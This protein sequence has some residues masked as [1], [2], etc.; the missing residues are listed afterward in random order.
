VE[1]LS[2]AL[3]ATSI[4]AG[5]DGPKSAAGKIIILDGAPAGR[6][7]VGHVDERIAASV[8]AVR[9]GAGLQEQGRQHEQHQS[10]SHMAFLPGW[11]SGLTMV[12]PQCR[13]SRRQSGFFSWCVSYPGAMPRPPLAAPGCRYQG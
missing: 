2:E 11:V 7:G 4:V 5:T 1:H 6:T 8:A 13:S 9:I 3:P 12:L 10:F